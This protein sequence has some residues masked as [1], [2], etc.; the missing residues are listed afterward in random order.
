MCVPAFV[1]LFVGSY[2][3]QY[4]PLFRSLS[5]RQAQKHHSTNGS[6]LTELISADCAGRLEEGYSCQLFSTCVVLEAVEQHAK[7][8]VER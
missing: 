1:R 3:S 6:F 5:A 8:W 4:Y 7:A 2:F